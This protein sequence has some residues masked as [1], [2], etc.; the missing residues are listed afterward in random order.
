MV[1]GPFLTSVSVGGFIERMIDLTL[2][3]ETRKRNIQRC[4]EKGIILPTYAQMKNP[5]LAPPEVKNGLKRPDC[6]T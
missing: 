3:G 6:G 4:R 5:D 1:L 2:H